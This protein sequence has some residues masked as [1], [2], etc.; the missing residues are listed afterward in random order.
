MTSIRFDSALLICP[1]SGPEIVEVSGKHDNGGEYAFQLEQ[2]Q[3]AGE[4]WLRTFGFTEW[5]ERKAGVLVMSR[6]KREF[7]GMV[8]TKVSDGGKTRVIITEQAKGFDAAAV[9]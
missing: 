6:S 8:D 2:P 3:G 5:V 9:L 4:A 7:T 1:E